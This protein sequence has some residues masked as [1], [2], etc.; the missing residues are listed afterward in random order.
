MMPCLIIA[1]VLVLLGGIGLLVCGGSCFAII[2]GTSGPRDATTAFIRGLSEDNA[3][4]V[5]K[6]DGGFSAENLENFRTYI[7]TL[8]K[9]DGIDFGNTQIK[10][11]TATYEGTANFA[12]GKQNLK[13]SLRHT[14]GE[15]KVVSFDMEPKR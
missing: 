8:G 15:W 12:G 3:T 14:G 6:H 13:T 7:K 2:K 10:N 1:I 9:F 4:L 11:S 5:S